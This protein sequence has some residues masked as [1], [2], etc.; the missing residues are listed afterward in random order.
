MAEQSRIA[1]ARESSFMADVLRL[2]SG[3]AIA[4]VIAVAAA[5]FLTRLYLPEAYGLAAVFVSI[6][7]IIG[8][9]AC[10]RY[11]YSIVQPAHD[12]DAVNLVGASMLAT[13]FVATLS[14][15]G[16]WLFRVQLPEQAAA[17]G[18]GQLLLVIPVA[19]LL[20]GVF[21]SLSLWNS[22]CRQFTRQSVAAV[23]GA[24][25][26]VS[27]QFGAAWAG[28]ATGGAMILAK[29]GGQAMSTGLLAAQLMRQDGRL[30]RR[31]MRW[32]RI[33]D[34]LARHRKFPLFGTFAAL[35]NS[36]S[37][38]LPVLML[39][40]LF[41]STTAGY[42][43][44]GFQLLQ[45]PMAL[46]GGSIGNV[47]LQRAASARSDG[48]VSSL[49]ISLFESLTVIS[50]LPMLAL[51]VVGKDL[52]IFLFGPGWAEAGLYAQ[53]LSMWA[54]VWFVSS[55]LSTLFGVFEKQ[56]QGLVIQI[57]IFVSRFASLAVGA[58]LGDARIALG[59]F[60]MA[61]IVAYGFLMLRIFRLAEVPLRQPAEIVMNHIVISVPF[62][63]P[64]LLAKT[65]GTAPLISV[66]LTAIVGAVYLFS[67]R[68]RLATIINLTE[69]KQ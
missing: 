25:T 46:V 3:T 36:L 39:A 51:A 33:F 11:E 48:N 45:V 69:S 57:V 47:F 63:V 52:F 19:V 37:W 44:L 31:H 35:L 14:A 34:G 43:A 18:L 29:L 53:I 30:F 58:Y 7:A 12:R 56:E 41:G 15:F 9:V 64:I 21:Q 50:L 38:Q 10:L 54:F 61:G 27:A 5:P 55:P 32:R 28:N 26:T 6:T 60:A 4:Q 68:N 49:V 2:A 1:T 40:F 13:L 24:S 42:Y 17:T 62:L 16:I 8:V 65:F 67:Q 20:Q 22:R 23:G 59:V 66:A